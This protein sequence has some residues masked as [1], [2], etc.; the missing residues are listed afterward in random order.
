MNFTFLISEYFLLLLILKL[1]FGIWF[2]YLEVLWPFG[3]LLLQFVSRTR[4]KFSFLL[5]MPHWCDTILQSALL[6]APRV[7]RVQS[8]PG[9]TALPVRSEA[10]AYTAQI[11]ACVLTLMWS[12]VQWR[13]CCRLALPPCGSAVQCSALWTLAALPQML[14]H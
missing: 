1:C 9:S 4:A 13:A 5:L 8:G 10:F 12:V 11:W 6:N 2:T 7:R 3:I 14:L